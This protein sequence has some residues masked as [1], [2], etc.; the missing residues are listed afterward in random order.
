VPP[1]LA[2]IILLL[3][4]LFPPPFAEPF[5]TMCREA[6]SSGGEPHCGH[7]ALSAEKVRRL[8]VLVLHA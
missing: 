7:H 1:V 3:P 5:A 8:P 2:T 4:A 6:D